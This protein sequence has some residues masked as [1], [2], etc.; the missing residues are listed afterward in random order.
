MRAHLTLIAHVRSTKRVLFGRAYI[1]FLS[2]EVKILH[3]DSFLACLYMVTLFL[4][5]MESWI[6]L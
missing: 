5:C 3:D 6:I 1:N 4:A 2:P